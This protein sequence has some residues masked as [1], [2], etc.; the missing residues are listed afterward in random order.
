MTTVAWDGKRMAADRMITFGAIGVR[1]LRSKIRTGAY[2]GLPALF[3]GAGT[4]IYY[5]AVIDW[6]IAGMPDEHK[7]EMPQTPDSF[8]VMV[9]TEQGV[10]CYIDSLRP[11]PLGQIPWALGTG[12]DYAL[13]AMDAGASARRAVEIACARD[14][15][16]GLDIDVVTL[17]KS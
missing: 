3:A 10:Y 7:P 1:A 15:G 6:L 8:T 9:V 12:A 16:S 5:E 14:T 11:I 13:G 17:R 4:I 2:H